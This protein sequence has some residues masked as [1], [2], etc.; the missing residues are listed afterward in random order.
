MARGRERAQGAQGAERW[1]ADKARRVQRLEA[2]VERG[3]YSG[4]YKH[5]KWMCDRCG[6][7]NWLQK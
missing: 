6:T 2:D 3:R 5:P 7:T 1:A 4:G